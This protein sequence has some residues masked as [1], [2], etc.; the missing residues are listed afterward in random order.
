M[1]SLSKATCVVTGAAGFIAS[2]LIDRLLSLG[3]A[4]IG[5]DN[6][7]TGSI[8]NIAG[9]LT[10]KSF[11]FIRADIRD[12]QLLTRL[13]L[14]ADITKICFNLAAIVSVPYSIE[15]PELTLAI[16]H[17]AAVSLLNEAESLG[18]ASF[19][20][21]GSAAEY[22]LCQRIPLREQ[23]ATGCGLA[24][25]YGLSKYLTTQCVRQ[26]PIGV[27]MRFF[28]VYGPRQDPSSPYSGVISKFSDAAQ[29]RQPFTIF[30]DG[31]QT[32]D[33]VFVQDIVTGC[34]KAAGLY[35]APRLQGVYNL[36][37][38]SRVTLLELTKTIN[39]ITKTQL[40]LCFKP[41]RAG[42]IKHS[43]ADVSLLTHVLDW[44][45]ATPLHLGLTR[46]LST[47]TQEMEPEVLEA[48]NSPSLAEIKRPQ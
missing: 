10:N 40:P 7:S 36:G 12:P 43:V 4:V 18:F 19:V 20:F 24:S 44:K 14:P 28:N 47:V 22:G 13:N 11:R 5:I 16:N 8:N 34:I 29:N 37:T 31:S 32:R 33:F 42:D 9:H 46:L 45:P 38:G 23:D 2:H 35:K 15:H 48:V 26:S 41:E 3:H 39:T 6:L 17:T 1:K 30:G 27:S 21:A 25:P